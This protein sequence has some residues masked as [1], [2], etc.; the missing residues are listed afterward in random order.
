M[1]CIERPSR[2]ELYRCQYLGMKNIA[3]IKKLGNGSNINVLI[4][5]DMS[6]QH[7]VFMHWKIFLT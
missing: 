4:L 5:F 1:L 2:C 6:V 3:S 7:W